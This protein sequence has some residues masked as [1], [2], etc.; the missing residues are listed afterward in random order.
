[1]YKSLSLI[2]LSLL[3]IGCSGPPAEPGESKSD[4]ATDLGDR[5]DF[6]SSDAAE[7]QPDWGDGDEDASITMDAGPD[8]SE[9]RDLGT[10]PTVEEWVGTP[11]RDPTGAGERPVVFWPRPVSAH[12]EVPFEFTMVAYDPEHEQLL[13]ELE[14]AP[15][16]MM[17]DAVGTIRWTP[18]PTGTFEF[19]VIIDDGRNDPVRV[20][21]SLAVNA[22]DFLFVAPEG[23][24]V[25]TIDDPMGDVE[26]AMRTLAERG[27][28]TIYLRDGVYPVAW[29]WERNE[30]NSPFRGT[31]ASADAPLVVRGFPGEWPIIDCEENGHGL[32]SFQASYVLFADLEVRRPSAG[33][34][35][36]IL[37][38][39]DHVVAQNTVVRDANWEFS[40]NCTGYLLRGEESV[41]H[42]CR[43]FNNYDRGSDHWN[44]S[45]YLTYP[46]GP[47]RRI[48]I[49]DSFSEGSVVGYKIKHAG[50]GHVTFHGNR[51]HGSAYGFGGMDDDSEISFNTFLDNGTGMSIAITDPSAF[52]RGDMNVHHNTVVRARRA[53]RI[54]DSYA[55]DGGLT[56]T[57][58]VFVS[59]QTLGTGES[60]VLMT[61]AWPYLDNPSPDPL[62]I[63]RNCW[64]APNDDA[65]FRFGSGSADGFDA[66]RAHGFD[67]QSV[68]GDP[69][70]TEESYAVAA[71]SP[72][73]ELL[74][75]GA[76]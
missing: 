61:F 2:V 46:S 67:A 51:D 17:I 40:R 45:N 4:A 52:T 28:G 47:D 33:E 39:G 63:D 15:D 27:S 65:G 35:G 53:L 9:S 41:C 57:E 31:H 59:D 34:R 24:G 74:G 58:N 68:W 42:R 76:W 37:L 48:Y 60:D 25:G 10:P 36:G 29:N 8:T 22:D 50:E 56:V 64:F 21:V 38:D 72:C 12:P 13:Y 62:H 1:M 44:S 6:G 14:G 71:T 75:V 18:T 7:S 73:S 49:I 66:W 43:A 3:L 32:W 69:A 23:N 20:S 30:V 5:I 26:A 16:G 55:Q 54:H 70:F 19:A 11:P